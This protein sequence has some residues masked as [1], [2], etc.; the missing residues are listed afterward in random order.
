MSEVTTIVLFGSADA[1]NAASVEMPDDGVI[2]G[3]S[4]HGLIDNASGDGDLV[5]Y[6][7]SFGAV[8]SF[9]TNDARSVIAVASWK[10]SLSGVAASYAESMARSNIDLR[11]G[12]RVFGGERV[13]LHVLVG[14]GGLNTS[15]RALL[16]CQFQKFT[17]RRR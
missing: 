6:E 12:V 1:D 2:L 13:Y 5:L 15:C 4:M 8:G 7:V 11:P 10:G 17:A 14:A 16:V 9:A 3:V